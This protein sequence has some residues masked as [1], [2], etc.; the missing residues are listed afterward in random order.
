MAVWI[1]AL[2]TV[3][4]YIFLLGYATRFPELE[5]DDPEETIAHIPEPGPTIKSGLYF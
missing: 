3:I 4:I 5:P 1:V 2:L